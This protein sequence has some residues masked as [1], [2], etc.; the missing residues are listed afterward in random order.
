[1]KELDIV[2]D[3]DNEDSLPQMENQQVQSPSSAELQDYRRHYSGIKYATISKN[4]PPDWLAES[5][6]SRETGRSRLRA[7]HYDDNDVARVLK[8][9]S[10][11]DDDVAG[12]SAHTSKSQTVGESLTKAVNA[13]TKDAGTQANKS[14]STATKETPGATSTSATVG[15]PATSETTEQTTQSAA[16]TETKK[17]N[18]AQR[19]KDRAKKIKSELAAAKTAEEEDEDTRVERFAREDYEAAMADIAAEQAEKAAEE[20]A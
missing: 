18:K 19:K 12:E 2:E 7:V 6:M 1:M 13:M 17:R 15:E 16:T 8:P 20:L 9:L 3:D 4:M 10:L 11:I 14:S 5:R